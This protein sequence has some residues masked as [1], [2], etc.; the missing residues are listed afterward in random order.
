MAFFSWSRWLRSLLTRKLSPVRTRKP[1]P[2][3]LVFERLESRLAPSVVTYTWTGKGNDSLF[4]DAKNWSDVLNNAP[5]GAGNED[6]VFPGSASQYGPSNNLTGA[7]F[8]SMSFA[9]SYTLA[10]NT[11][12]VGNLTALSN[13]TGLIQLTGVGNTTVALNLIL[14]GD[15]SGQQALS[16]GSSASLTI[17]GNITNANGVGAGWLKSNSAGSGLLTLTGNNTWS[18]NFTIQSGAG[19]VQ[20]TAATALGSST[21]IVQQT[22]QLQ[23]TSTVGTIDNSLILQGTGPDSFGA[24]ENLSGNNTWAGPI[25]M[26]GDTT[27]DAFAGTSLEIS[28]QISSQNLNY[29]VTKIGTGQL[30]FSHAGGNIYGGNT[31]IDNGVLTIEDPNA[32]GNSPTHSSTTTV[33][34]TGNTNNIIGIG[35]LQL[36]YTGSGTGFIVAN[37]TLNLSGTGFHFRG[38][39]ENVAGN[40]IWTGAVTFGNA[41]GP[42]NA[43][44]SVIIQVDGTTD[45]LLAG[46]VSDTAGVANGPDSLSLQGGGRLIL[47]NSGNSYQGSTSVNAGE[48][49]LE[50]SH[51]AGNTAA[52][53]VNGGATLELELQQ[54]NI[55]GLITAAGGPQNDSV[56]GSP[57]SMTFAYALSITGSGAAPAPL[58]IKAA[59]EIGT[60]V[61]VTTTTP[62]NLRIGETVVVS[63]IAPAGYDGTVVV[64]GVTSTTFTYTAAAGLGAATVTGA[65]ATPTAAGALANIS[66]VNHYTGAITLNGASYI[67]VYPDAN[68]SNTTS[69]FPVPSGRALVGDWSL[70]ADDLT[71]PINGS[72]SLVKVG[73]GQLVLPNAST[74]NGVNDIRQGWI[75]IEN[76]QSLGASNYGVQ[77]PSTG[78]TVEAGAALQLKP[79]SGTSL[80]LTY[81]FILA[82]QGITA[83]SSPFGL[84][85]TA[86]AGDGGAIESLDGDNTLSGVIQLNGTAGIGVE[87]VFN[88][89]A[90][91]QLNVTGNV[92]DYAPAGIPGGITKLGAQR[93]VMEAPGTFSGPVDIANGVLLAQNNT[94]LGEGGQPTSTTT[95]EASLPTVQT[96]AV[97]PNVTSFT[98]SLQ[99]T[100]TG[101]TLGP[102]PAITNNSDSNALAGA[103]ATALNNLVGG[104]SPITVVPISAGVFQVT[105]TGSLTADNQSLSAPTV[106]GPAGATVTFQTQ[107][108]GGGAALELGGTVYSQTTGNPLTGQVAQGL[109]IEGEQLIVNGTGNTTLNDQAPLVVLSSNTTNAPVAPINDPEAFLTAD[110]F[111]DGGMSLN[112]NT[113]IEIEPNSRLNIYGVINDDGSSG[114]AGDTG[115]PSSTGSNLTLVSGILPVTNN[116]GAGGTL[117]LFA[118]NTYRGTTYIDQGVLTISGNQ[119]LGT[120]GQAAIQTVTIPATVTSFT[121]SFGGSTTATI[122]YT[123]TAKT[124]IAAITAALDQLNSIGGP[125]GSDLG[126]SVNV[127]EPTAGTFQIV[128][129]GNLVGFA[130][131]IMGAVAVSGTGTPSVSMVQQ[132]A[133]GTIIANGASLQI[134]GDNT[135]AGEPLVVMGTGTTTAPSVPT[136]WFAVGPAPLNDGEDP[137][138]NPVGGRVTGVVAD[139]NNGNIIYIATAGGGAWKTIDGGKNWHPIFDSIPDI[140]T[141]TVA[142]NVSANF[143]LTVGGTMIGPFQTKTL[144]APALQSAIDAAL[145]TSTLGNGGGLVNVTSAAGPTSTVFTVTFGGTLAGYNVPMMTTSDAAHAPVAVTEIGLDPQFAMYT[146]AVAMEPGND[147]TIYLGTG[148]TDINNSDGAGHSSNSYYGTGIYVSRDGGATWTLMQ[149]NEVQSIFLQG[150]GGS[151]DVSFTN[152]DSTGAS[153]TDTTATAGESTGNVKFTGNTGTDAAA[154]QA[155]LSTAPFTNNPGGNIGGVGGTVSVTAIPLQE[156][157]QFTVLNP[158]TGNSG[159]FE[160]TVD[161]QLIVDSGGNV[162]NFA[163]NASAATVQAALAVDGISA[164]VTAWLNT[165]PVEVAPA[166][167]S[168][169]TFYFTGALGAYQL[170][171]VGIGGFMSGEG[172]LLGPTEVQAGGVVLEASFG[173]T[174]GNTTVPALVVSNFTSTPV[175]VGETTNASVEITTPANPFYGQGISTID[176]TGGG[177]LYVASG[178]GGSGQNEVQDLQ[179]NGWPNLRRRH[180]YV[181]HLV[182]RRQR[183]RRRGDLHDAHPDLVRNRVWRQHDQRRCDHHRRRDQECPRRH[184]IR[185]DGRSGWHRVHKPRP[186]QHCRHQRL[187]RG[188]P[189]I[190]AAERQ[191][192][193][194]GQASLHG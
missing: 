102:T 34:D 125:V 144:T 26:S 60:T 126:G 84:I 63:G 111:W 20:I 169:Y 152:P 82:G 142:T 11:M 140:Q 39:L 136:Q 141:V 30:I 78:V 96:I 127:T 9:G 72:G 113:T 176:A 148:E 95:V 88:N 25:S 186:C 191:G 17:T 8:N 150:P 154:L 109:E 137:G 66:G 15:G 110:Y 74:Y 77:F 172:L 133:G 167:A 69:Y 31:F 85:S 94:A 22:A 131:P 129:G 83:V 73:G 166:F 151:Y 124:D 86:Q 116:S 3:R 79:A 106:S 21:T 59:S 51:A 112:G 135:I 55:A 101:T 158:N 122:N 103:I 120:S 157:Q 146:G 185:H 87:H 107:R 149:T 90:G 160:L 128:F 92:W 28:G 48:L 93:L 54:D 2:C 123:G 62:H 156:I 139:P 180:R 61:T 6:L 138:N 71:Q 70:T 155:A 35:S 183:R 119:A 19:A 177:T 153:V 56:T 189:G 29:N 145:A 64:T 4:T 164:V 45:L 16:V 58:H 163:Y 115:N 100:V 192:G 147:T 105:F 104:G 36:D 108:Y 7:I 159:T 5:S 97:T 18:E 42:Y 50:D 168:T 65:T 170:P 46:T 143:T 52:I 187:R 37:E 165:A 91:Y 68:P 53:G 1:A 134:A 43:T 40:N 14:G 32:L 23:L 182:H 121:L 188:Y 161:G 181:Y 162:V 89:T 99:D 49:N 67:G 117:N 184:A 81:N 193:Q 13:Q 33:V 190:S 80:A 47:T 10:G 130:Q 24:L 76:D 75:T 179:F 38:A 12:T 44:G 194:G 27:F 175:S 174:L 114:Y 173:G 171:M 41:F 57:N 178:D 98:L 118:V 132:G